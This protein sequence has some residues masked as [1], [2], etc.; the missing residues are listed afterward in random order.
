MRTVIDTPAAAAARARTKA[1]NE[2]NRERKRAAGAAWR[3][4]NAEAERARK[5]AAYAANRDAIK[6]RVKAYR[7]AQPDVIKARKDEYNRANPDKVRSW[8]KRY[9]TENP[10]VSRA[11]CSLRNARKRTASVERVSLLDV[12]ARDG[13]ACYMCGVLTDPRAPKQSRFKAEI[14]H[15]IPLANGGTHTLDNLKCACHPCNAVKGH[16]LTA[17]QVRE[18]FT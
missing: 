10:E 18:M 14:E 7:D 2:A 1:W 11:G 6:A 9:R 16:R 17:E 5:A 12:I 15:V 8:Q 13:A 4:A 3:A